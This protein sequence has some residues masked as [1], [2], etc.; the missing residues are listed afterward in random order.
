MKFH[1]IPHEKSEYHGLSK[2][3]PQNGDSMEEVDGQ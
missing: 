1:F 3:Q 2:P